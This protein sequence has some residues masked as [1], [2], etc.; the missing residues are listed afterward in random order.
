[1]CAVES[2]C[3]ESEDTGNESLNEACY[4][5]HQCESKWLSKNWLLL[6]SQSSTDMFCNSKYLT[7]ISTATKPTMIHCN[8]RSILCEK[9]GI[10]STNEFGGILVMYNPSRICN[11]ISFKIMWKI[12]PTTHNSN[13][14]DRGIATVKV[15][16]H[17]GFIKFKPCKKGLYYFDLT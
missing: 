14:N 12:F 9:M 3:L 13:P 2:A 16:T 10:F 1:M 7:G 5:F 15:H 11:I 4:F 8:T 17:M 6:D